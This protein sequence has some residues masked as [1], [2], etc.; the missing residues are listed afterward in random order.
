MKRKTENE[1]WKIML[2]AFCIFSF[3]F[4]ACSVPN[5]EKSECA[6][7]RQ[8]VK[9]FYSVHFGNDM[10]PSPENLRA[11]EKFLTPELKEKLKNAGEGAN[12]Y[13]T[14]T[15]DYPKAFRVGGCQVT[16]PNEKAVFG[17]LLFW[18]DENRNEQREIKVETVK[19]NDK[20]L[21]SNV[22]Q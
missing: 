10:K 18:K 13:F 2:L 3:S 15:E 16:E 12:D 21:V 20:W 6:A 1:K 17:V 11:S 5:L 22:G 14:A 9:E 4:F 19:Q 8:T 7:A